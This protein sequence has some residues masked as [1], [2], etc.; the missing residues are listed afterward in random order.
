M[1]TILEPPPQEARSTEVA[2]APGMLPPIGQWWPL[3][4]SPLRREILER[5]TAPL[6]HP[7]VR[8]I[9]DLC[10]LE[11]TLVPNGSIRLG[12]NELAYLAGW[13]WIERD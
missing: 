5:P 9:L 4:E 3:L 7:V 11:R 13:R 1:T 8:R 2:P 10:D 6:P 12:E